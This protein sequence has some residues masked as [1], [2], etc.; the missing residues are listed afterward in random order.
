MIEI[1]ECQAEGRLINVIYKYKCLYWNVYNDGDYFVGTTYVEPMWGYGSVK[2]ELK[3]EEVNIL[4]KLDDI[5][6]SEEL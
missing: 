4:L 2:P 3:D 5:Y 6:K 1:L